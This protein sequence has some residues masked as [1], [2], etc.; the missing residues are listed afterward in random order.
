[1]V[2]EQIAARGVRDARVLAAMERVPRHCFIPPGEWAE[3]HEDHPVP[4]GS[5]QTI[6]QPYIVGLMIEA[7]A[8][9]PGSRIL[10]IGAG[11]GYVSA[12]LAE[13]GC[14]VFAMEILETLAGQARDRLAVLG[15]GRVH[16]RCGDGW[17]GWPDEAPFDGILVSAAPA[18]VPPEL[19]AQLGDA[20]RLVIPVGEVH[21]EL[22]L[23]Q[24]T[25]GGF[26]GEQ[27]CDVRFVRMTGTA[28]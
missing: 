1:M 6:S 3:A 27:L 7:L 8:A 17:R 15:Y 5:G 4:I 28:G 26:R 12:I 25:S 9:E 18:S 19:L 24:R 13:M 10:E 20:G 14:E 2:R 16:L 22:W 11:S 23:Y 21:Q